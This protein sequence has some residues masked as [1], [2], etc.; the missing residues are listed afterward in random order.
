M[1]TT[2][3]VNA[4]GQAVLGGVA[5]R[6]GGAAGDDPG[7]EQVGEVAVPGNLA[8]TDDDADRGE[9]GDLRGEVGCAV[10]DLLR[11]GLISWRSAANDGADPRIA[12]AESVVAVDC[13]RFGGKAELVQDGVHEVAGAV[14]GEGAA[15]AV[16]SVGA[17]SKAEDEHARA[18]IPEARY[19]TSP[20]LLVLVGAAAGLADSGAVGAEARAELAGDDLV[21]NE[22]MLIGVD[23]RQT[24]WGGVWAG[25][26]H[27]CKW[28]MEDACRI[29]NIE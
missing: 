25:G 9:R 18:G 15:G 26:F 11:R 12:Q 10:A 2:E 19:G 3:K 7:R 17:G 23:G 27:E 16:G 6:V 1:I 21:A 13:P 5:E 28:E 8:Q 24:A 14:S 29:R 4:V 22:C 20:V